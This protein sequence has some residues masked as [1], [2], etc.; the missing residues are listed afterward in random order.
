[1]CVMRIKNHETAIY[2]KKPSIAGDSNGWMHHIV[3]KKVAEIYKNYQNKKWRGFYDCRVKQISAF[4][5]ISKNVM[6]SSRKRWQLEKRKNIA[7]AH[8]A[9]G[10]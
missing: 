5:L 9:E 6:C 1:M 4:Q 8:K 2:Y 3:L 7:C 10:A